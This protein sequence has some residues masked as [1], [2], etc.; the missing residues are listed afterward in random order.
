MGNR[1]KNHHIVPKV[2][3]RQFGIEGDPLKI[4]RA[5][6]DQLGTYSAPKRKPIEKTFVIRDYNTI[7]EDEQRSDRIE[8]AFY[9]KLDDFLGRILPQTIEILDRG[10]I[11]DFSDESLDSLRKTAMHMA[12]RTPDFLQDHDDFELGKELVEDTL[13]AMPDDVPVEQ[14]QK[15]EAELSNEA[16]LRD[17]GRHIRVAATI[18]D[19]QRVVET[20]SEFVP[21]WA[22][23][24]TKHSFIL[25]SRMVYRIGNG[26]SNGLSN[27]NME[28]WMPICPKIALVLVRDIRN[29]IPHRNVASPEKIR[30]I[31]QYAAKNSH[32]IASHSEKL[33]KSLVGM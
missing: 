20:L 16:R 24:E 1:A 18:N 7:L 23:S 13:R 30:Q 9:A 10:E 28:M 32:E 14:R 2:L 3:Q 31:N 22:I 12:K 19:S 26:G 15:L 29:G 25:A 11:P 8:R 5:K 21:R 4:W 17:R 33:L 6:K 27:P